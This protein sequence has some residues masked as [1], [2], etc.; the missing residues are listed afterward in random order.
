MA[1]EKIIMM[2]LSFGVSI[3]E[4][5]DQLMLSEEEMVDKLNAE[6]DFV[7]SFEA[8]LAIADI[9]KRKEHG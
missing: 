7:E 8:M 6:M 9:E 3:N 4:L 1:N 5:A 2:M